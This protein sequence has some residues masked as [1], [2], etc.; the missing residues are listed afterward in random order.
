MSTGL[1]YV[2]IV[3][4]SG[5]APELS[6]AYIF[7]SY[8]EAYQFGNWYARFLISYYGTSVNCVVAIYATGPSDSGYWRADVNP[9][10]WNAFD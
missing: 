8:D 10:E 3:D 4:I 2:N 1:T 5:S 9:P 6:G 7:S